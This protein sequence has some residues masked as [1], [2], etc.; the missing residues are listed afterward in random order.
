MAEASFR[1]SVLLMNM[2][3]T[4]LVGSPITWALIAMTAAAIL[5]PLVRRWRGRQGTQ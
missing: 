4:I 5:V 1:R 3:E 2:D